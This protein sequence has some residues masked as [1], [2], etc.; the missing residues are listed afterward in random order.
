MPTVETAIQAYMRYHDA[1]SR[2]HSR[3]SFGWTLSRFAAAFPGRKLKDVSA[4]EVFEFLES[5][6]AG[7]KQSTRNARASQVSA[8]YNFVADTLDVQINNPCSRGLIKKLYK[9]P[10]ATSPTLPDKEVIDEIIYT[11]SGRDRLMLELM[12]RT[13]MRVSEVLSIRPSDLN[14]ESKTIAIRTPKSGRQGEVVYVNSRIM[15]RLN[16][17]IRDNNIGKEDLVFSLSYSTAHRMVR[18]AGRRVGIKLAPHDLRRHAATQASRSN[19]P[20]EIVSK[21][22]L[23]HADI[24]TT[25]R[26]LG[27]VSPVEASRAI[28]QFLA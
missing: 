15:A 22:I 10:R 9:S 1:H 14:G 13:A 28:E 18:D 17:Y 16:E 6:T 3:R 27:K 4:D 12:G 8:M 11:S 25:Q 24:A 20:L 2:P 21:V 7:R 5:L 23:R 26:Y 19:M